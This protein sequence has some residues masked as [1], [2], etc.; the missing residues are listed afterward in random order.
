MES[1]LSNYPPLLRYIDLS[2]LDGNLL[3]K[4]QST[5]ELIFPE[6]RFEVWDWTGIDL[7]KES[8]WKNNNSREDSIQWKAA[9]HYIN[10]GFD[11]VFD[12]DSAGEAAD[13]ICLKEENDYIRLALIHC[14]YTMGQTA[15]ERV[16]DVVEVS[17]QAIRSAKWRWKFKDL[18]KH[19]LDRERRLTN[20]NRTTRFLTGQKSDINKFSMISR[21]K[22]IK[23]EIII[24]Q[25]GLSQSSH[26]PDQ[27]VVLAAAYSY[28]KETVGVDLDI[29][30]SQ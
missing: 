23:P 2:E 25:P 17:S 24:V 11:V 29:I 22:E 1:F 5:Q 8:I 18:C 13:L 7:T 9:N 10:G 14:K 21:F 12:D 16:K 4:P 28:L 30:C 27:T 15:G 26:T 6:Q 3:I 20:G 19:I